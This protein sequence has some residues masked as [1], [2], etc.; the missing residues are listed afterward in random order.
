MQVG[1]VSLLL[2]HEPLVFP[3]GNPSEGLN[4][5]GPNLTYSNPPDLNGCP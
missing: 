5:T 4:V 3:L 1:F 2:T